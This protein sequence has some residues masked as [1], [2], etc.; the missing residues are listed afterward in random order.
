MNYIKQSNYFYRWVKGGIKE[1]VQGVTYTDTQDATT[2]VEDEEFSFHY[3]IENFTNF[4]VGT[5]KFSIEAKDTSN[6]RDIIKILSRRSNFYQVAATFNLATG[7]VDDGEGTIEETET[8]WY[9]CSVTGSIS[10][11]DNLFNVMVLLANDSGEIDYKGDGSSGLSIV[12]AK[13]EKI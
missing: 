4:P 9:K 7:M 12:N 1:L 11:V 6:G 5:Y 13:F 2:I 3:I 10:D 8:G